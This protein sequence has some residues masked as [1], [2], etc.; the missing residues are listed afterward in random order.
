MMLSHIARSRPWQVVAE[1]TL[2]SAD[3]DESRALFTSGSPGCAD[4]DVDSAVP[5]ILP[6]KSNEGLHYY[7]GLGRRRFMVASALA[8]A[9]FAASCAFVASSSR[10]P[11]TSGGRGAPQT[12]QM[13]QV[14]TVEGVGSPYVQPDD[15][16]GVPIG[17]PPERTQT[18][19]PQPE[20]WKYQMDVGQPMERGEPA[21][22]E[23]A[24]PPA[25]PAQPWQKQL[26]VGHPPEH[27]QTEPPELWRPE[28]HL[29]SPPAPVAVVPRHAPEV[30]RTEPPTPPPPCAYAPAGSFLCPARSLL[31]S[32]EVID[33]AAKSIMSVGREAFAPSDE[34]M[35]RV[36]TREAFLNVSSELQRRA[37]DLAVE[38]DMLQLDESQKND[39]LRSLR[40]IGD[41]RVQ[42]LG[43]DVA[44][45]SL[46]LSL[47][48]YICMYVCMCIYIYIYIYI[49]A[50][51]YI[52]IYMYVYIYIYTYM[53]DYI[54][55][56]IYI[57]ICT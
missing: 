27:T 17:H 52:Y 1:E 4:A 15:A 33:V 8:L 44:Y 55:V 42:S 30:T 37:H 24:Q 23:T 28:L 13:P 9:L 6:V 32:P 36:M 26:D 46:S 18:E 56:Y 53:C 25:E 29:G 5:R 19:P 31:R 39:V 20:M 22:A 47:Y 40:L 57:Y 34:A 38:L 50:Y 41:P 45:T 21:P 2:P 10:P 48:I 7:Q 16:V 43:M 12:Q 3:E 14:I 49:C 54:C 35:V 51:A 11:S